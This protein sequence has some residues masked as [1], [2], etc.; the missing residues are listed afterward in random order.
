M[1]YVIPFSPFLAF[2]GSATVNPQ[3]TITTMRAI[4]V[5]DRESRE[6]KGTKTERSVMSARTTDVQVALEEENQRL[7]IQ[8][9]GKENVVRRNC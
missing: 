5:H 6:D 4:L 3:S 8:Q 9:P 7:N 2:C 1:C